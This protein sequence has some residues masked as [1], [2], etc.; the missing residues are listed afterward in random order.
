ML[1]PIA[2]ADIRWLSRDEGGRAMPPSSPTYYATARFPDHDDQLFSVFLQFSA[3]L[4]PEERLSPHVKLRFFAPHLVA[5]RLAPGTRLQITEGDKVVAEG[6]LLFVRTEAVEA[7]A[8][9]HKK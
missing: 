6:H 8:D 3:I 9:R 1:E 2:Y 4:S 5:Q 7:E